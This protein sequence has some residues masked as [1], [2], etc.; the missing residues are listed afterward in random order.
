MDFSSAI[1]F[2]LQLPQELEVQ[3]PQADL[4][5]SLLNISKNPINL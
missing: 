2:T 1:N 4:V 3:D 5:L